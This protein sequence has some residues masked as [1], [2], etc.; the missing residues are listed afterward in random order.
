[1][2]ISVLVGVWRSGAVSVCMFGFKYLLANSYTAQPDIDTDHAVP[3]HHPPT[4]SMN[5][6]T[7]EFIN[8][9]T[10]SSCERCLYSAF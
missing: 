4:P 8:H 7:T 2:G 5:P 6:T 10:L 1:M 9:A 3:T